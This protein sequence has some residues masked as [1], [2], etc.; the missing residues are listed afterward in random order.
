MIVDKAVNCF[1][2]FLI[3]SILS[4]SF[5]L[6]K[7]DVQWLTVCLQRQILSQSV[8][9]CSSARRSTN[10]EIGHKRLLMSSIETENQLSYYNY[11]ELLL[12]GK[13]KKM[14]SRAQVL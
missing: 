12:R 2:C 6:E 5:R 11:S 8:E 3:V 1:D 10:T 4:R 9:N 13:I 7:S 14:L